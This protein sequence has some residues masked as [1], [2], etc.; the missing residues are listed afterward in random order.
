MPRK[1]EYREFVFDRDG[2]G[3][4]DNISGEPIS[5]GDK[6]YAIN[7]DQMYAGGAILEKTYKKMRGASADDAEQ[8]EGG[9]E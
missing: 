5:K 4:S 2:A 9:Q 6:V 3:H 7:A 8:P 1:S